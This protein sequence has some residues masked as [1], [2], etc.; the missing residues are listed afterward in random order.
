MISL[1][2]RTLFGATLLTL[3]VV[4]APTSTRAQATTTFAN[5][6][7]SQ[8]NPIRLSA[9][10]MR[11]F[12]VNTANSSLSVF[13][14]TQ[15]GN[16]KLLAEI[17]VGLGPVSVNP[18]TDTEAWVVNQVSNSISVVS[19]GVG[20]AWSTGFVTATIYL[21]VPTNNQGMSAGE[22]MDVVFSGNTAYASISRAN[23]I[24]VIN[25]QTRTVATTVQIFGDSPRAMAVSPDGNTVYAAF[26][27]AGNATTLIP[28]TIAPTPGGTAAQGRTLCVPAMNPAL[29]PAPQVGLIVSAS[30]PA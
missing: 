14:V 29:P 27:L 28:N 24:A 16:P 15:P 8:T 25:T 26:A 12:A 20:G 1:M 11:L 9:D 4:V 18:R 3:A 22:P 30:D 17:P 2:K 5:F 6:E 7:A 19:A 21:R 23:Q 13:D 10:G